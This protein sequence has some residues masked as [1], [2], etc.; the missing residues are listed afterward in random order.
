MQIFDGVVA[1]AFDDAGV[2]AGDD[3][4]V[5]NDVAF[6]RAAYADDARARSGVC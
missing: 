5:E 6:L 1:G 3:S 2:F 4:V